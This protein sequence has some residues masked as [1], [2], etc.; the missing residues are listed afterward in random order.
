MRKLPREKYD[1]NPIPTGHG[2]N[3]PIYESHVKQPVGIGLKKQI[4]KVFYPDII[5]ILSRFYPN[6]IQIRSIKNL[7]KIRIKS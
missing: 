2:R 3:Q 6:L 5:L 7:D 1:L 4:I